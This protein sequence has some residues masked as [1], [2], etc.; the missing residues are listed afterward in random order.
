MACPGSGV[1]DPQYV[2]DMVALT[3]SHDPAVWAA[4]ADAA[5]PRPYIAPEKLY[6]HDQPEDFLDWEQLS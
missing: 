5:G 4:H 6:P 1:N 3:G 2:A